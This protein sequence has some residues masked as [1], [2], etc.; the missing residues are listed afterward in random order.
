MES[1]PPIDPLKDKVRR[2]KKDMLTPKPSGGGHN[3][4]GYAIAMRYAL[5]LVANVAVGG[6]IGYYL[7]Q[8]LGTMP[9]FF[10]ICLMFGMASGVYTL[11]KQSQRAV[12]S[13][14]P[15]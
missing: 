4:S 8:W 12:D 13:A 9:I 1:L 5:D 14:E 11:H 7:D 10:I 15:K 6:A 3:T 2:T